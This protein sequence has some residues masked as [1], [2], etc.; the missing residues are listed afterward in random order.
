MS[1]P[2]L[3]RWTIARRAR[4]AVAWKAIPPER[5]VAPIRTRLH[6]DRLGLY[7]QAAF[8]EEVC[9]QPPE[10]GQDVC[11]VLL[12]RQNFGPRLQIIPEIGQVS[13]DAAEIDRIIRHQSVA[14]DVEDLPP[15][16]GKP[17]RV[18]VP[19]KDSFGNTGGREIVALEAE[20]HPAPGGQGSGC[21]SPGEIPGQA[22][23]PIPVETVTR[24][25]QGRQQERVTV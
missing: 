9:S 25:G 21:V 24:H 2:A 17:G 4:S 12:S 10:K 5:R 1:F 23:A 8:V 11:L 20:R 16:H 15:C 3:S 13:G 18:I 22:G 19:A 14:H 7:L 6:D